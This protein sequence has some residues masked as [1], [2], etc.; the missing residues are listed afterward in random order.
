MPRGQREPASPPRPPRCGSVWQATSSEKDR[1]GPSP[2][3]T[4]L[5]ASH[6]RRPRRAAGEQCEDHSG[7]GPT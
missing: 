7:S 1:A 6:R 2:P 5:G 4:P 3:S